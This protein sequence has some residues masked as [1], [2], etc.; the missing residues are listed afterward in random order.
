MRILKLFCF[1]VVTALVFSCISTDV[2][3]GMVTQN[4][5]GNEQDVVVT[6]ESKI[7]S[8]A[9]LAD[10]FDSNHI[11]VILSNTASLSNF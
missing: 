6:S 1:F 8:T 5:Q 11:I 4:Q 3:S 7:L 10:E 2:V 9:T